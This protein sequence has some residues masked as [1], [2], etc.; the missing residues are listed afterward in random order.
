MKKENFDNN[1][2]I[3]KKLFGVD[4]KTIDAL[5]ADIV[6]RNQKLDKRIFLTVKPWFVAL[7]SFY[8]K[9]M[10][11]G[12]N[13]KLDL[14]GNDFVFITCFDPVHRVKTLPLIAK[15]Y[16]YTKF[17]LP[18]T[19]R[20]TVVRDYCEYYKEKTDETVFFGLFNLADIRQYCNF[21]R[22]NKK[23]LN[24]IQCDSVEDAEVLRYHIKRFAL[25]S[26]YAQR[27]FGNV[28]NDK[29]WV[30]EHDK[31]FFIP[32]INEFR[33]KNVATVQMQHGTFFNPKKAVYLPLYTDKIICS[34][35]REK[36][37]YVESGVR[38]QDVYIAGA[39]LQT[40]G[41]KIE[42]SICE[43]YDLLVLLT[44][45]QGDLIEIQKKTLNYINQ[46][47]KEKKVLLRF[48]PRSKERD[49][50]ILE[51]YLGNHDISNGTSLIEDVKSA[52]KI[53]TFSMDAIF[54]IIQTD[55][56][57]VAIVSR[58]EMYGHYLDGI[59]YTT[60]NLDISMRNLFETTTDEAK[61]KYLSVFGETKVENIKK[62][63]YGIIESLKESLC[64]TIILFGVL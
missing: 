34:S 51:D 10:S 53:L 44:I 5:Y 63:F 54:G 4:E 28:T 16:K 20:P 50:K 22:K 14:D 58:E 47:Y 49:R 35:E 21:L 64:L 15:G 31:F 6:K 24:E 45:T 38:E 17:F 42:S 43:K 48:R 9:L 25:Y 37:L 52:K 59:C 36:E 60:D 18:T 61:N 29:I 2:T 19:T 27:V 12:F 41:G 11:K 13:E 55:K 30:F 32:V 40:I 62:N 23:I 7:V 39:P 1:I 26:I 8:S 46:H 56:V 33:K 3:W 57:F